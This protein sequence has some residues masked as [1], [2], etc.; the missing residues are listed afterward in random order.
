MDLPRLRIE[1]EG[2]SRT[3]QHLLNEDM[4]GL[5]DMIKAELE[6]QLTSETVQ[7]K[8]AKAVGTCIDTAINEITSNYQLKVALSGIIAD[9]VIK[10]LED[11]K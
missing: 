2:I 5:S 9:S 1:L 11:D 8:I 4:A 7:L 6:T 10:R 3:V